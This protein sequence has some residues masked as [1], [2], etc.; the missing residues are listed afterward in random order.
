MRAESALVKP[1]EAPQEVLEP[2]SVFCKCVAYLREIEGIPIRGDAKTVLPNVDRPYVGG[3]V[4]QRFGDVFHT[5]VILAILPS[6]T[7]YVRGSN[8][9][10]CVV[11]QRTIERNSPTI[12]GYWF[13]NINL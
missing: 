10:P 7:L 1:Q 6:G 12:V 5:D 2:V 13:R 11:E 3:V 4:I 8:F 9:T